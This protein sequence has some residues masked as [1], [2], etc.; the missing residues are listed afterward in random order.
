[1]TIP[2]P[3]GDSRITIRDLW[4]IISLPLLLSSAVIAATWLVWYFTRASCP[5]ELA[6]VTGCNPGQIARYINLEVLSK[7]LTHAA[8]AAGG[9]GIWS[10]IMITRERKARET[11][12]KNLTQERERS[13]AEREQAAAERA[14]LLAR[15]DEERAQSATERAQ[16]ADDRAELLARLD[17]E[18][19]QSAA[20]RTQSA[21]DRSELLARLD[22]AQTQ[23]AEERRLFLATIERLTQQLNGGAPPTSQ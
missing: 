4:E 7:I 21:D 3:P 9:G 19:A 23:A 6:N 10:Y 8:I 20:E 1:M 5:P 11:A 13:A 12:E 14:E 15:L 17:A 22:A 18:R 2:Q 16:S